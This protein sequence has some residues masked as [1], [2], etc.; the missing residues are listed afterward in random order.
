MVQPAPIPVPDESKRRA[1]SSTD[2]DGADGPGGLSVGV[3]RAVVESTP[4]TV[5]AVD[6]E[7]NVTLWNP[8]AERM[9]G[10]RPEEVLGRPLPTVPPDRKE[11]HL[12][13]RKRAIAGNAVTDV[14]T[15]RMR[16][17]G[18][19]LDVRLSVSPLYDSQGSVTGTMGT[20]TDI[21]DRKR[22]ERIQDAIY[23]I[24]EA[25]ASAG[26]LDEL[27]KAIHG[28][29]GEL[30]YA[31]N[32]YIALHDPRSD[33]LNFAYF[34]DSQEEPPPPQ[35]LRRGLTEFVLRTRK[36]LLASP[37]VFAD[38]LQRGDVVLVG[39]YSIDWLGVPLVAGDRSIGVLVVQSYTEGVRYTEE[40]RGILVYVSTQV[41]NAI[42]RVRAEEALRESEARYRRIAENAEDVIYRY[43]YAEPRG[44]E[45]VSPAVTKITGYTPEDHYSDPELAFR[46]VHPDD[47]PLLRKAFTDPQVF[48]KPMQLRWIRKDGGVVWTEQRNVP[49]FDEA[50]TMVAVEGIARDITDRKQ[51]EQALRESEERYRMLFDNNPQPMLVYEVE[52]LRILAVN[53]AA[54]RHYGYAREEFLQMTIKDI[55]PKE[56]VPALLQKVKE[57][58]AGV[59]FSGIWRHVKK[60]GTVID[61][62]IVSH[63]VEFRDRPARIVLVNDVTA[64]RRA[65]EQLAQ[66]ER[67]FRTLFEAAADGIVLLDRE[68]LMLDV[69]PAAEAIIGAPRS[70]LVGRNMAEVI[71]ANELE[72][73]REY[74]REVLRGT[75]RTE[76]FSIH[77]TTLDGQRRSLEVRSKATREAGG[78]P[79]VEMVLRDV[80]ESREMQ[81]RLM[82]SERLASIGSMAGYVAH[83]INNP[84]ANISLLVASAERRTNDAEVLE[85]LSK[86]NAQ[87]R[88]AAGIIADLLSFSKQ[89]TIQAVGSDLR[90]IIEAA[91]DQVAPYRKEGVDVRVALGPRPVSAQVDPI[92]M[93]EVFVNLLKNGLEATASGSVSVELD[94]QGDLL[95]IRV[96]DTG[97]GMPPEMLERLFEPFFTTKR[98]TG[99]T[100]LGLPLCRNV[101]TAHGGEIQVS[102]EPGRGSTFTVL[103]PRTQPPGEAGP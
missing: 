38:L 80:T 16:K 19:I 95:A 8:A 100:G 75:V 54:I 67:R 65:E 85:K 40:D 4:T 5:I 21:T 70:A 51:A 31:T 30:M 33:T 57:L 34:V 58:N 68:G 97:V 52:T 28:I 23:R 63:G 44:F 17:D 7:G 96:A 102:S 29:V 24:S 3:L 74:M 35:K 60:D 62:D 98:K 41:A 101:V 48:K 64:R 82:E 99:G 92:Q 49:V 45:Y 66:S 69:N 32:F 83:E 79:R 91:V 87:R 15:R 14:E 27:F 56:D 37:E 20:L 53:E 12:A 50:G 81:R 78:E 86:I 77:A 94:D 18:S 9:F 61:V 47:R 93:Q 22:A 59:Q 88:Q 55:R 84:L 90:E 1:A 39:P 13:L 42:E 10:W 11:E 72:R 2:I 71:P 25:A 76:P 6:R 36:P 46:L 73:A 103:I 43:R 89:R 26:N